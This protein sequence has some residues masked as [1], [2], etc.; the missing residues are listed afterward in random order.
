MKTVKVNIPLV[1]VSSYAAKIE[2][3]DD[4][5]TETGISES[6]PNFSVIDAIFSV[7]IDIS[8]DWEIDEP[9]LTDLEK[10]GELAEVLDNE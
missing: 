9:F 2:V 7:D 8:G 10:T 6:Q 4:F 3:P 1:A 5:N